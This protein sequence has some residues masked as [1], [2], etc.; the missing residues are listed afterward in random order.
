MRQVRRS[1]RSTV[2]AT[3]LT[4]D[5]FAKRL[6]E[7][8]FG[9]ETNFGAHGI[10]STTTPGLRPADDVTPSMLRA[11]VT[12]VEGASQPAVARAIV[13]AE[14]RKG[15]WFDLRHGDAFVRVRLSWI[16]PLRSFYL[17]IGSDNTLTVS[18][19]PVAINERVARGDLLRA[20]ARKGRLSRPGDEEREAQR[21]H[22]IRLA[23]SSSITSVA[24]PPIACTRAS[25]PHIRSTA[26]SRM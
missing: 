5:A 8:S 10:D 23:T 20:A 22:T 4:I 18:L 15:E 17:F 7:G 2:G 3:A 6:R 12:G 19:D 13:I 21:V 25:L 11:S 9:P 14:L 16:S 26:V 24:P 1:A